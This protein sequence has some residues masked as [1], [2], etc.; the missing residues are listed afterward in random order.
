MGS[1]TVISREFRFCFFTGNASST[2]AEI[3]GAFT[4]RTHSESEVDN[5]FG[6][7]GEPLMYGASTQSGHSTPKGVLTPRPGT[8]DTMSV[9]NLD[10]PMR[11]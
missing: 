9:F 4:R 11:R 8:P 2:D 7:A 3:A 6:G 5:Y 1:L 10:T